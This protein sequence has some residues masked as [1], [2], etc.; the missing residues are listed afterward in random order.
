MILDNK[1]KMIDETLKRLAK[2]RWYSNAGRIVTELQKH[3]QSGDRTPVPH[4]RLR[5]VA[6]VRTGHE[7][8][9]CIDIA[10]QI[11]ALFQLDVVNAW[12]EG[13]LIAYAPEMT[14]REQM[15]SAIRA[16][17]HL[18]SAAKRGATFKEALDRL[19]P[20]Y[21][22]L[23]SQLEVTMQIAGGALHSAREI[24]RQ[25][26]EQLDEIEAVNEGTGRP[27]NRLVD[28]LDGDPR[29]VISEALNGAV[30]AL[31]K[32]RKK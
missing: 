5:K 12:G 20:E 27:L 8:T 24:L 19:P 29:R 7:Y 17:G 16:M 15:R 26:L 10:R 6:R 21:Q 32:K 23:R 13:Y 30:G 28:G 9:V 18:E 25:T 1:Q 4:A 14:L 11:L 22:K 3:H 31:N 2:R